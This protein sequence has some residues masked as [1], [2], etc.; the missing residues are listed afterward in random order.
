MRS[1]WFRA[2]ALLALASFG[3][4]A[5]EQGAKQPSAPAVPPASGSTSSQLSR[6]GGALPLLPMSTPE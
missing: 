1:M 6:S 2:A 3:A 4:T 5:E